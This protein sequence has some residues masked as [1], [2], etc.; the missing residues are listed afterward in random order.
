MCHCV[1]LIKPFSS[2]KRKMKCH[3]IWVVDSFVFVCDLLCCTH[4]IPDTY[5]F[6]SLYSSFVWT[7][8]HDVDLITRCFHWLRVFLSSGP[9]HLIYWSTPLCSWH[10]DSMSMRSRCSL[11]TRCRE[12]HIIVN[13]PMRPWFWSLQISRRCDLDFARHSQKI[14]GWGVARSYLQEL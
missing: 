1:F 8:P 3:E 10:L 12:S 2:Q 9:Q 13:S 11:T 6:Q 4:L 14:C 5:C 7:L